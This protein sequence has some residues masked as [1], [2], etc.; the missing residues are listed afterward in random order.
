MEFPDPE[1]KRA[2]TKRLFT[3]YA[4]LAVF[5]AFTSLILVYLAQGYG[6][7]PY[8]GVQRSSL[9]FFASSP[10]SSFVYVDG[11]KKDKTDLRLTLPEGTH[12][13][14]LKQDRYRDWNKV[15]NIDGGSVYYYVY[16]KLFP[17][18]ITLGVNESYAKAP[19]WQSQSIDKRWL[20]LQT[21]ADSPTLTLLDLLKP[22][23]EAVNLALP[24]DQLLKNSNGFGA[25]LPIEWADDNV[26]LLLKQTLSDGKVA[27][28]I[29]DRENP[30]LT[31]N[32]STKISLPVGMALSLRDKKYDKY[33]THNQ[34]SGSLATADLKNGL[35]PTPLIASDVISFDS[36]G[37][38]IVL[39]VTY[40]GAK[41][42]EAKVKILNN[43][44]DTYN[45]QTLKRDPNN[46][47]LLNVASYAGDNYYVAA[48]AGSNNVYLY[49]DPL[50]KAKPTDTN[51]P[52]P[53]LDLYLANPEFVSFSDNSRFVSIQAGKKFVVY[54]AEL[55]RAHR[56]TSSLSIAERGQQ[57]LWMDS[58]RLSAV[59]DGKAQV[60][61]F[62][63]SNVQALTASRPENQAY[64]DKDY[65]YIY[66]LIN[67]A[68]GR[69]G[70]QNGGL[71]ASEK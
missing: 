27:Y 16:P 64:F 12:Q 33:Y 63:G 23:S 39:F 57:A 3:G 36:Y 24:T 21:Q 59:T 61:D 37:D 71:V 54:D 29:V 9:V 42:N 13:I 38:N 19:V 65:K 68:D 2:R 46:K 53:F 4:L 5:I 41:E 8:K 17:N 15:I 11:Q 10:V 60:F 28:I 18:D 69:V 55:N 58:Y 50:A 40:A 70:L 32:V 62:D 47:Y 7:D 35:Q 26:H 56:Y 25:I 48:S 66:T 49:R 30:S 20:V 31:Q 14:A 52:K 22:T 1:D 44:T 45:L 67:Q 34:T 6:Y 43:K 51:L